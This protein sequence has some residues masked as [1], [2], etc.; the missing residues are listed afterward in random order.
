M[1][2]HIVR[3]LSPEVMIGGDHTVRERRISRAQAAKIAN[4]A[5]EDGMLSSGIWTSDADLCGF[6]MDELELPYTFELKPGRSKV[7][8]GDS[9]LIARLH[10]RNE[11]SEDD[12]IHDRLDVAWWLA[13]VVEAK[14]RESGVKAVAQAWPA[15]WSRR[16]DPAEA[17]S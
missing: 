13:D 14:R 4:K 11:A 16:E 7:E 1:K 17:L 5:Y 3:H 15:G 2:I 10:K 6:F 12:D 8:T 9:V